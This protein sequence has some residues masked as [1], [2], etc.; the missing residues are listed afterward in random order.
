MTCTLSRIQLISIACCGSIFDLHVDH[1]SYQFRSAIHL[2]ASFK[3][4]LISF[5]KCSAYLG[6]I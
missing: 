5:N 2:H 3:V 6:R 1:L 4:V